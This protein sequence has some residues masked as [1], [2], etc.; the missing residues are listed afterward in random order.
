LTN[1][2]LDQLLLEGS[3]NLFC[4]LCLIFFDTEK[5]NGCKN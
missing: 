2:Q 3:K 5:W 1:D 4:P